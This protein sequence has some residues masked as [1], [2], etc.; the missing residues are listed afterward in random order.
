MKRVAAGTALLALV[1]GCARTEMPPPPPNPEPVSFRTASGLPVHV[2]QTGWVAVKQR[3][4]ELRGPAALRIPGIVTDRRWTEW[5][6]I[7][8]FVVEHPDGILVF[9]TD[10]KPAHW[11]TTPKKYFNWTPESAG[12]I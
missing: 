8:F 6:P 7:Q 1:S 3:F 12:F 4:R 9:D 10:E 11:Y 2:L 5:M